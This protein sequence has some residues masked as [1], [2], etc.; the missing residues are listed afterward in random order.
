MVVWPQLLGMGD[1]LIAGRLSAGK[2]FLAPPCEPSAEYG[3]TR[4]QIVAMISVGSNLTPHQ[5]RLR[6]SRPALLCT[7]DLR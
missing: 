6:R 3:A 5:L 2:D 7:Q 4:P 1:S